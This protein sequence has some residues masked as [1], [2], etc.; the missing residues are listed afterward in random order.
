MSESEPPG[1][2][3]GT[4]AEEAR[5]SRRGFLRGAA[6]GIA[7]LAVGGIAGAEI[8][9][10]NDRAAEHTSYG[11]TPLEP[12][13]EPGFDHVV[14][15]MFEN[16]SFDHVL[17]RLYSDSGPR[18]GQH[19]EGLQN[20]THSNVGPDGSVVEAHVY[21]GT[22]D[23]IMSQPNPDPG[24]FYPHV[25]T[26]LFGHIDPPS[27]ADPAAN[28]YSAP[29]NV[30]VDTSHPDMSGFIADYVVNYKLERGLEPSPA[31]YS[32]VMGGF[33]PDMLPVFSTLARSFGVYD[34][35]HA[36][37][38]SQTFCNRS[39]FHAGTS[40]GFVTNA[41]N[42]G[43]AK[44]LTAPATPTIFNRLED[45][46]ISWRVYYDEEQ[47]VSLT[48]ML[49]APSI[50]K[51]WKSNFR[52]MAQFHKD[53]KDGNLPAYAF[54][55]PRMVFDHNDMHPPHNQP[56]PPV[57]AGAEPYN[58]ALSDMRA[59]EV[60]LAEVYTSIKEAASPK[61]SNAI[62]TVLL[63]TFDEHGGI[64]DHVPPPTVI[65]PSG[66]EKPGEMGFTFNRLGVRVPT[67]VI[68]AYTAA[69]SVI[70]DSMHHGSLVKTLTQLH[71]LRPLSY[72]DRDAKGIFS[73]VNLTRP[74]QPALWP[75][76]AR[77]YVPKN[78]ERHADKQTNEAN[79]TR[80]LT[81]PA[82]GLLGL[83]LAK[84]EPDAPR[85]QTYADAYRILAKHGQNLFGVTD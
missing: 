32:A 37:V 40:H 73:A 55:E 71:G 23:E 56:Q 18:A 65:P 31:E 5:R 62:N 68:S 77:P 11:F 13:T 34:H 54:I 22:T 41:Q 30:P 19:F 51:Y 27:N 80:P 1:G 25:N 66:T 60:L 2:D 61:G 44:W 63:L 75:T 69:G 43:F 29:F 47:V 48:G 15:V 81:S 58:S 42:G 84:Y 67:I 83:L 59:G 14:V 57:T 45:A 21:T 36:A 20:G 53:A 70:N 26:Q 35:W 3:D 7:G 6:V 38:P 12:R 17:G 46:G 52:G 82:Q 33:S 64:Y 85:P 8:A 28:G 78:P 4:K 79:H 50:Q 74:R 24:E 39:F 10:S 49:S 16:R 9:S 72:R 76:V